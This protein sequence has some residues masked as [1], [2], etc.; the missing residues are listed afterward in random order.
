MLNLSKIRKI[1]IK[2]LIAERQKY[3]KKYDDSYDEK[4]EK[5][6]ILE[7]KEIDELAEKIVKAIK[8]NKNI[9][10]VDFIIESLTHLGHAP[11][12]LY[13]DNGHF[14][15]S[16]DGMQSLPK[17]LNDTDDISF[18]CYVEKKYWKKTIRQALIFYLSE[19]Y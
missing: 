5:Y 2:E 18:S 17:D 9:L 6:T 19:H 3:L 1:K 16:S 12:I 13:D 11:N 4:A 15:I 14:A 7:P 10:E 8:E